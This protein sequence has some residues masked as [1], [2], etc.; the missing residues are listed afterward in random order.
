M[1]KT[2]ITLSLVALMPVC[3]GCTD[4]KEKS[5]AQKFGNELGGSISDFAE[6]VG[7]GVDEKMLVEVKL[8]DKMSKRGL[9][10][11]VAK[12]LG[13]NPDGKKG[14][15]VYITCETPFEGTLIAKAFNKEGLE[16][17]RADPV[18]APDGNEPAGV[19]GAGLHRLRA[20]ALHALLH[21]GEGIPEEILR[22]VYE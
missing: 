21:V 9:N 4:D 5:L 22:R 13:L 12:S 20:V 6:G 16:I 17:G 2:L 1:K 15:N 18:A 10:K 3:V 19:H 14:I 11:T 8:T 7:E